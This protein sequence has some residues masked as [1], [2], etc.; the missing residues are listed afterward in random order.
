MPITEMSRNG[1]AREWIV[2]LTN[3]YI[4]SLADLKWFKTRIWHVNKFFWTI[5]D[6]WINGQMDKMEN[7]A[8]L[9]P[10]NNIG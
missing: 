5:D 1:W 3:S 6:N 8:K 10:S 7:S 2:H 4:R 9:N